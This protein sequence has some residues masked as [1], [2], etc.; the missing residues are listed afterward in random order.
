VIASINE[1]RR[2]TNLSL[3]QAMLE[4]SYQTSLHRNARMC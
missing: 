3:R 4:F 2:E 1:L